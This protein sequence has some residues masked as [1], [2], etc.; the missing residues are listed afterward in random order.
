MTAAS[1]GDT[2]VFARGLRNHTIT[3]NS[4]ELAIS[5]SLDIEG[6]GA[7]KPAISGSAL[8]TFAFTVI[9]HN[10]ASTSDDNIFS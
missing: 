5:K 2:I 6:L 8:G 7:S 1:S 9:D 10:H 3:L 4:G